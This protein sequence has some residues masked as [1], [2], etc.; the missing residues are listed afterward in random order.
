MSYWKL[1]VSKNLSIE[2]IKIAL[3]YNEIIG[4][5]THHT[6]NSAVHHTGDLES[7]V[8][9]PLHNFVSQYNIGQKPAIP[10]LPSCS[11]W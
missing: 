4:A 3:M 7:C 11:F 5:S 10:T 1:S 9:K 6:V 8:T 2:E